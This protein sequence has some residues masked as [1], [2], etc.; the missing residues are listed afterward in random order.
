MRMS[1]KASSRRCSGVD[2][3]QIAPLSLK[4]FLKLAP[5]L[6]KGAEDVPH[7]VQELF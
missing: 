2:G 4:I 6:R 1:I 7:D 3:F 5:M